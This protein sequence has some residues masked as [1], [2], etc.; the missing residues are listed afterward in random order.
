VVAWG[1]S[2]SSYTHLSDGI[3]T[4]EV[5]EDRNDIAASETTRRPRSLRRVS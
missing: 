4:T 3:A 1:A 2:P 5:V